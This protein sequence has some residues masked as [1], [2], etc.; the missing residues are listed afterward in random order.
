MIRKEPITGETLTVA[1][2]ARA[3]AIL[4]VAVKRGLT[5]RRIASEGGTY[6]TSENMTDKSRVPHGHTAIRLSWNI[7]E[8]PNGAPRSIYEEADT[9]L[10]NP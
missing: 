8:F 3:A 1:P 4:I 6:A 2:N 7:A 9:L 5:A 10:N